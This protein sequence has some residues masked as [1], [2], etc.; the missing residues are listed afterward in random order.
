MFFT[1]D[2]SLGRKFRPRLISL[3]KNMIEAKT[4]MKHNNDMHMAVR[5]VDLTSAS[6]KYMHAC[7]YS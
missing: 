4:M 6:L 2:I 3:L 5:V 1:D 7:D